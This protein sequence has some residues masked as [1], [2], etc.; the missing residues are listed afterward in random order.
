VWLALQHAGRW[1]QNF[2]GKPTFERKLPYSLVIL[3]MMLE[4][5]FMKEAKQP[6]RLA[7]QAE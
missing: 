2:L 3:Y 1:T 4:S 7:L 5:L 6:L